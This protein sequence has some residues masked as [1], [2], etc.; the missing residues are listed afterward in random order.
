MDI[1]KCPKLTFQK[2]FPPKNLNIYTMLVGTVFSRF[3]TYF[4]Y[5]P[6]SCRQSSLSSL[7]NI[8]FKIDL[9]NIHFIYI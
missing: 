9:K 6:S 7:E 5:F 2:N 1:Y 8:L 3:F 4:P